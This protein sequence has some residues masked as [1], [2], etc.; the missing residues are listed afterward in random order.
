MNCRSLTA[1]FGSIVSLIAAVYIL[2]A[3][4]GAQAQ[5]NV[6]QFLTNPQAATIRD[7]ALTNDTATLTAIVNLE[8]S[9]LAQLQTATDSQKTTI[10]N[11]LSAIGAGIAQAIAS[12]PATLAAIVSLAQSF[13]A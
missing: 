11:Q 5:L 4:V 9:L 7:L 10:Q 8:Q 6:S 13:N 3:P 12:N 2:T 1:R